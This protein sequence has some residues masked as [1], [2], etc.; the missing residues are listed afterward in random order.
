M[1]TAD[2]KQRY[3]AHFEANGHTVVP[4]A[5]LPAIEDP[6]LLFINA[7]MVQFVPYFLGQRTPPFARAVSVQKCLRTPDIDEVG[8]TSRHGTF[9]QM[10][11]NFSFGDYFKAGAIP[12]AWELSTTS[13]ADG[14][15]GL[16][17]E[18]IWATVYLDDDEAIELWKQT[19]VPAERIVRRGKK[20]NFWSMGIP[21]PAGPCS[22]LYYDRGPDYGPEGGPEVD[23]DRYLEFWNL[24]FMQYE[25]TDV[26]S[27]EDFTIVGDLPK[28]N[29]DTGMGL[30]R[31]ASILQ[32]VDNLYEIDEVRP[33]LTRAAEMTGKRYGAHSGHAAH[34]SHPDDVRLRVIADHVRTSLMLIGDGVVPANEG[35]GYVLR[36]IMRR[37]IRAVRLLGWQEAALPELLPV[38]R[39]CMSPSYPELAEDFG[40]ISQYAYAEEEAFL[41]T[42]RAG[43]TILDTAITDTKKSGRGQLS[44]AQAFQLHDT[45]GFPID[46]TLEIAQE[47]GLQVDQD[48]FRRLMADQRA[49]AKADAAARKTGHTDLSAYRTVLD[50]GGPVEFTGYQEVSRESRVRALLGDGGGIPAASEGDFVELVLDATPFYAEGGGQQADTGLINVGG[51]QVEVVD[52]QQPVPGL[53]VH[54]ARVIRGEVRAGETG[55]AEIDITRRKA[56]SRSHTATHLIHQT[57]RAFLGESA[58]QAGSLNAPGRLRFDFNTPGAVSPAVL[59]DVEQQVNEVLLRDLEVHAFITSQEEARRLGAMALFGEKYGDEVRVVEVGDYARELCGGTHVSRSGQLGLVKILSESSIGSGVRRVEALVGID[60]FGFLAREHLLVARLADLFRVPGDQVADRVEQTVA[61]L[62]DAEKELEKMRA[63]MVLGGAGALAGQARDVRGVAFVGAEAPEGAAGNDV[64]TLAQEIRG[65][66]DAGRPAVVAVAART[67]GKASLVVAVNAAGK[68]RGL[69][70]SDLV[71]G[72]LSGRGGGSADVAQGG[73]VPAEQAPGLLAAVEK[74]VGGTA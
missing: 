65:K 43:T 64:R 32:G 25:I 1:R 68:A 27:K 29:I 17:P 37:A 56:V 46:L 48:G 11:G 66:I 3:L 21:G 63:Q 52:V 67:G 20:D 4:S 41:S 60:A 9:F 36:R 57:M 2:I 10:N 74:A 35:R 45:Y 12:L 55:F 33:I 40:R 49:R 58:T 13:Q 71:K 44:G 61:A 18:R 38:A 24:V 69:S 28:K 47:Q 30:E 26:K 7:G 42:L 34:Q 14:G 19:G 59:H 8:K 54:R 16:D 31:I 53:I 72:A 23:E 51:G 73:G 39:D 5:P 6:N 62:R 15:F 70:A 50:Q 22:E